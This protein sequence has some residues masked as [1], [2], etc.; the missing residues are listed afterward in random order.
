MGSEAERERERLCIIEAG[1]SKGRFN[2]VS[3]LSCGIV[4]VRQ[5]IY[6][7]GLFSFCCDYFYPM[8][9]EFTMIYLIQMPRQG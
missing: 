3:S 1:L 2:W 5:S 4:P 8:S 6:S 7:I 9:L